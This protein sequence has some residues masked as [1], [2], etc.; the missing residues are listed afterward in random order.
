MLPASYTSLHSTTH[1][2]SKHGT[3]S[4]LQIVPQD[5]ARDPQQHFGAE[6]FIVLLGRSGPQVLVTYGR[7]LGRLRSRDWPTIEVARLSWDLRAW[8]DAT[9]PCQQGVDRI[10]RIVARRAIPK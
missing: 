1:S 4:L 10:A 8:C 7:E 9:P 3:E 5:S 6:G 2:L